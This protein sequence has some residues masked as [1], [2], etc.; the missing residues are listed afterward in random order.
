MKDTSFTVGLQNISPENVEKVVKIM[1]DTL[2]SVV[3]EGFPRDRIEAV[4]HSYELSLKHRSGILV[5]EDGVHFL[6]T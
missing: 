6:Y 3:E 1:E 2:A 5:V 4:L